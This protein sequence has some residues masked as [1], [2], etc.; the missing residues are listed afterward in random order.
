MSPAACAREVL[1]IVRTQ[2]LQV[3]LRC[4]VEPA[5][6]AFVLGDPTRLRQIILN[7]VSNAIKFTPAGSVSVLIRCLGEAADST[8]PPSP[9]L[10]A[11]RLSRPESPSVFLRAR[12]DD[13]SKWSPLRLPSLALTRGDEQRAEGKQ[14]RSALPASASSQ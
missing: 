4:V 3:D 13:E 2:Q 6:P 7:L 11:T 10:G 12:D 9:L 1:D 14:T 5:V 8:P